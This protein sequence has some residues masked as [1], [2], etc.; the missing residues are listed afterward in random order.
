MTTNV[1]R[2]LTASLVVLAL[3]APWSA[4]QMPLSEVSHVHGVGFDPSKP[5]S[6]LLATHCGFYRANPDGN[7]E[8]ASTDA[9]DYMGFSPDPGDAGRL[10][11]SGHPGQGGNMGVILSTDGCVTWQKITDGVDGPVDFHAMSVTLEARLD[12]I[13][14]PGK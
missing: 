8:T 4:E 7:A 3:G 14:R 11:A 2:T 13:E 1:G 9:N 12:S 10:L 6:I 5:G